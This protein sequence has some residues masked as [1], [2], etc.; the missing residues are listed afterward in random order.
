M[1]HPGWKTARGMGTLL[2]LMGLNDTAHM[3]YRLSS[4]KILVA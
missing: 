3:F 4:S 2:P 1:N